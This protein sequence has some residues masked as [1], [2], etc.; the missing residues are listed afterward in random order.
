MPLLFCQELVDGGLLS[1]L[2]PRT[3][4][5]ISVLTTLLIPPMEIDGTILRQKCTQINK[6]LE[7]LSG[8]LNI[9]CKISIIIKFSTSDNAFRML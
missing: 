6:A 4:D 2:S 3:S 1:Q 8:I 5:L 7:V 9:F